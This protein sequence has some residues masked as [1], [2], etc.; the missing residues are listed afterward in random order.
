MAYRIMQRISSCRAPP[1]VCRR[2]IPKIFTTS[3]KWRFSGAII[4]P[5]G[6]HGRPAIGER[7]VTADYQWRWQRRY[8]CN[9]W[10]Y[11]TLF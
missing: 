10:G 6:K 7:T 9:P 1:G 3:E 11:Y 5:M 4:V 8:S 2:Y